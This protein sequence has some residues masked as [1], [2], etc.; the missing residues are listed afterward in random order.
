[1]PEERMALDRFEYAE[2]YE[3]TKAAVDAGYLIKQTKS[4]D[5]VIAFRYEGNGVDVTLY[6]RVLLDPQKPYGTCKWE[7]LDW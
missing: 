6:C 2:P 4:G 3:A 7:L 5:L 1:M